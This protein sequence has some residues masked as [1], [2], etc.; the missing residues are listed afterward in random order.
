[1][2]SVRIAPIQWLRALAAT[3]ILLTHA[4]NTIEAGPVPVAG[5]FVP[6][7]P[8][9]GIFGASGVDLFFVISGFVMA[10]S[11]S[12]GGRDQWHFLAQRWLRIVPLFAC[13]SAAYMMLMYEPPTREGA[14]MSITILPVFDATGYHAPALYPGWTLGFEF[15]FYVIVAL[16]M[17]VPRR[18]ITTLI[19]LTGTAALLGSVFHPGWAPARLLLNPIMLEFGLGVLVWTAWRSRISARAATPALIVGIALLAAG[20]AFG[21]GV[22]VNVSI[23]E[24]VAGSSGYARLWTW[25]GPWAL[26]VLGVIDAGP[27]GRTAQAIALVGDASYSTYLVHPCLIAIWWMVGEYLPIVSAGLFTVAF[28]VASTLTG[29]ALHRW[30]ERPLLA[31]VRRRPW[32][33]VAQAPVVA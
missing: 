25:G 29:L 27:G 23:E 18:R 6:S 24:A 9:L 5:L 1:M 31:L 4:A 21:L 15:A 26:V 2:S 16:A 8:N 10:Q 17:C 20:I 30:I 32:A 33:T 11:L 28:V 13:V 12:T 7:V 14:L 19:A 22:P 3:L